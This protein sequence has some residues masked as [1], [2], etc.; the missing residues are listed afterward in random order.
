M[1]QSSGLKKGYST[2]LRPWVLGVFVLAN[3]VSFQRPARAAVGIA[4]ANPALAT[5]GAVTA[6]LAIL[7][8]APNLANRI[9]TGGNSTP[10]DGAL[11]SETAFFYVTMALTAPALVVG[12][13]LLPEEDSGVLRLSSLTAQEQGILRAH[14]VS[15]AQLAAYEDERS[16]LNSM[17]Q[18]VAVELLER[19]QSAGATSVTVEKMVRWSGEAWSLRLDA[20][21]AAASTVLSHLIQSSIQ[22]AVQKSAEDL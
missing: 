17:I 2:R 7:V 3:L 10:A 1:S 18:D 12:I 11:L 22:N 20:V 15:A 16:E 4:T 14:G 5:A 13:V 8:G 19:V 9:V 6:G 21:S